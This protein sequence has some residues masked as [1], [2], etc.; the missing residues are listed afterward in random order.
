MSYH[1][2][3]SDLSPRW[4]VLFGKGED[5]FHLKFNNVDVMLIAIKRAKAIGYKTKLMSAKPQER[6]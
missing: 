4:I 6:P 1:A 3:I 2:T 5:R